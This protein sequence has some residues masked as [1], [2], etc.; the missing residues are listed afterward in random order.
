MQRMA[1]HQPVASTSGRAGARAP[2]L[3][4]RRSALVRAAASMDV[5]VDAKQGERG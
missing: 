4:R 1:Q 5:R 2:L 3:G